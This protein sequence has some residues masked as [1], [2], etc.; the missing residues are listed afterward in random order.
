MLTAPTGDALPRLGF[1]AE[2]N[3]YINP[4]VDG[5][6]VE[7]SIASDSKRLQRLEPFAQLNT[8]DFKGMSLLIKTEGKCTT[9]HISMA[10]PWLKF[11]GHL[12]NISE[13]LLMGAVNSFNGETNSVLSSLN[14]EYNGVSAVAKSYKESGIS[15]IVIA[16][17][18]YGEGSSREHAAMEPR[19][20][21]VKAIV[22]KSFARI[23]ETNLKKQGMLALTFVNKSD[24][25]RVKEGDK[26][27]IDGVN[28]ISVGKNITLTINHN[29]GSTDSIEL[30]HTYNELQIEWFKAGS[31]LNYKG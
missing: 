4:I 22:A 7:V 16:E 10:G 1:N 18:N 13:N 26:F 2:Y 27:T 11:R 28:N 9:D 23:H 3:G 29:D 8:D 15:S 5:S 6:S 30:Q 12:E 14:N 17:E 19:F 31:A 20:L 25:D 24:Y 21:N